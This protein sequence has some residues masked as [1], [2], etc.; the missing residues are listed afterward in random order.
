MIHECLFLNFNAIPVDH[1]QHR[2]YQDG[3][4]PGIHRQS[5]TQERN[6]R[7]GIGRVTNDSIWSFLDNRL[8]VLCSNGQGKVSPQHR[9]SPETK[10][11]SRDHKERPPIR[12]IRRNMSPVMIMK[13]KGKQNGDKD[14]A[15]DHPVRTLVA[16]HRRNSLT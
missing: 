16:I 13:E 11:R 6:Q 10:P 8:R 2:C 9:N 5:E 1:P 7:T 15:H 14:T 4:Q 3:R 12:D